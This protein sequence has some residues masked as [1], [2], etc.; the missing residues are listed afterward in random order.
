MLNKAFYH[1]AFAPSFAQTV[2]RI[3]DDFAA[4][5]DM[6]PSL[7]KANIRDLEGRFEI[8]LAAP[9][10]SKEQISVTAEDRTLILS[11]KHETSAENADQNGRYTRREFSTASFE[12]RFTLPRTVDTENISGSYANGILTVVLPKLAEVKSQRTIEING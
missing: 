11:G 3:F 6:A 7:V 1:P 12:R 4:G 8:E 2:N 5:H 9:G 10:F